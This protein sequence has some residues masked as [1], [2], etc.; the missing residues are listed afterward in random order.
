MVSEKGNK[1]I[2]E[3]QNLGDAQ[4]ASDGR[5]FVYY[6]YYRMKIDD[7]LTTSSDGL[8][9]TNT[10]TVT[11]EGGTSVTTNTVSYN[12]KKP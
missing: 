6:L 1:I 2:F 7:N 9:L 4:K 10:A 5:P 3:L 11:K 8:K 12:Y